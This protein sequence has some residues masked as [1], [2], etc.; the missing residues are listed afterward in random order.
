MMKKYGIHWHVAT[1][2]ST[3][4]TTRLRG[5]CQGLVAVIL[6]YR[7]VVGVLFFLQHKDIQ[8]QAVTVVDLLP[9]CA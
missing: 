3:Q 5:S 6:G 2:L 7:E 9:N 8:A 4:K 1:H